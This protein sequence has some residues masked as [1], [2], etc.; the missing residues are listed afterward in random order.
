[1]LLSG[2]EAC[3][4][5]PEPEEGRPG[6]TMPFKVLSPGTV[7]SHYRI[8]VKIGEGGMGV[9]YKAEDTK[10]KRTVAL[11][12]LPPRMLCDAEARERFEH[13]AQSASALNHPNIATIYE[14]DEA[15]ARCFI[16]MEYL[17]G[18]SLKEYLR[19]KELSVKEIL[20]LTTLRVR[21]Y[22]L[23][24][25]SAF[26]VHLSAT[27][28]YSSTVERPVSARTLDPPMAYTLPST[29]TV[30]MHALAVGMSAFFVHL[31]VA[32]SYSST[33]EVLALK[34]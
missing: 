4:L 22:L 8:T 34:L 28:S 10:L 2:S 5:P 29:T 11:K 14:I 19:R 1:M 15:E 6:E 32:G 27:G 21:A 7:I 33:V 9:V 26:S 24:G 13:E 16:A 31:P 17:E 18:G 3:T 25:I 23:V 20:D 30:A 12:F